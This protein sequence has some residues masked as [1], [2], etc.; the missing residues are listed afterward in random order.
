MAPLNRSQHLERRSAGRGL[1]DSG[2]A[3]AERRRWAEAR[4]ARYERLRDR[5]LGGQSEQEIIRWAE[6]AVAVLP[7]C[8][9][10]IS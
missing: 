9:A 6:L 3:M 4:L 5:L 2:V 1:F 7:Q 10:Q 8:S